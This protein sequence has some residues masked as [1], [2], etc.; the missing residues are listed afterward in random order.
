MT[1]FDAPAADTT[2]GPPPTIDWPTIEAELDD[3]GFALTPALLSGRAC[4]ELAAAF[5][6]GDGPRWRSTVVMRRH[7]FGEGVYRYFSY[8]LPP[9]VH[10]LR[11]ELYPPLARIANRWA[12]AIG[13][14]RFPADHAGLMEQCAEAGQR[15]PTALVLRYGPGD[16]NCLHQDV[17]GDVT[18]P[19]QVAFLLS[20][21][22][23]DFTGGENVFVE[24]RPRGQSRPGVARPAQGQGIVFPVRHRPVPSA[25]GHKRVALRHGVSTVR[26]GERLALGVIFHDAR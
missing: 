16:Y 15:R 19:L 3:R 10:R 7:G 21:P 5:A 13:G 4:H 1:L 20:R 6:D 9:L 11:T 2:D 12:D 25:R 8:P 26:T 23:V 22:D 18:F 24:Q 14:P 17:Y